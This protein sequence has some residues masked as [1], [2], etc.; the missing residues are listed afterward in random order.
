VARPSSFT[1][2]RIRKAHSVRRI[3]P[4][5]QSL[6]EHLAEIPE[7][8]HVKIFSERLTASNVLSED[9][10]KNPVVRVG[11][12]GIVGVDL[13]IDG[14]AKIVQF[15]ALTSA[16]KGCGRRIVAAVVGATPDDWHLTVLLDWSGGFW[17]RMAK[18]YPRLL[19]A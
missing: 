16:I 19:I 1:S 4:V 8:R 13:L 2:E 3:D 15:F 14:E 12:D 5:V 7:L 10:K 17:R 6:A 9:N 11:A 18:D